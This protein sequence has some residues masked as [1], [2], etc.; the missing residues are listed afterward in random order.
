MRNSR[1]I[2][3]RIVAILEEVDPRAKVGELCRKHGI[4]DAIG[5]KWKSKHGGIEPFDLKRVQE[6]ETE[7]VKP[8][9]MHADLALENTAM[10]DLI[11][12]KL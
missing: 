7:N 6:L 1:S 10:N 12:R 3:L 9:R 11:A 4:S 5:C 2:E 8:R